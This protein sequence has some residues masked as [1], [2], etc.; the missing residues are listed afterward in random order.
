[1]PEVHRLGRIHLSWPIIDILFFA[2][3][4][5]DHYLLW[6]LTFLAC[7]LR[8]A[9]MEKWKPW[10]LFHFLLQQ[11]HSM[12]WWL[13][14]E[15]TSLQEIVS[16]NPSSEHLFIVILCWSS[17]DPDFQ[18]PKW[19]RRSSQ[20]SYLKLICSSATLFIFLKTILAVCYLHNN[21]IAAISNSIPRTGIW[22]QNHKILPLQ[23]EL[24]L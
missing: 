2:L 11:Q 7:I 16:S 15:D 17:S 22:T 23:Q 9:R 8:P 21:C 14:M 20:M 3:P 12:V 19:L 1:M 10:N 18:T 13:N 5:A 6:L 24:M 4:L